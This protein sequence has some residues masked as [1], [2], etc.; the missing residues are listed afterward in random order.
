MDA[1]RW[2]QIKTLFEDAAALPAS[3]RAALLDTACADDPA[4]RAEVDSLLAAQDKDT[5]FLE[6]PVTSDALALLEQSAPLGPHMML[7]PYHLLREIGHGGMGVVYLAERADGQYERRVAIKL[8]RHGLFSPD[9]VRRFQRERQLL[10][11][12]N[13]PGIARLIGGGVSE[14]V[15]GAS[16]GL[17][18]LVMEY[19][20]GDPITAFASSESLT[21]RRRI[22]L[23]LDVCEAVQHANRAL[24]V[25]RDLKPSNILVTASGTVKL[26]DFGVARLIE[27]AE[28]GRTRTAFGALTPSYAAPEQIQG[29]PAT[30]A[31]DVYALGVLLYELLTGS[32]P[33]DVHG[34]TPR[35]IE[36]VICEAVPQR[37]SSAV[38]HP[39]GPIP[40]ALGASRDAL[41]RTLKG[42]LD[43]IVMTALEKDPARRY[44]SAEQLGDDLQRHLA[45]L[46]IRARPS[47]AA[48]RTARFIQRHTV[49]LGATALIAL[50]LVIG[51]ISTASQARRAER[52]TLEVREMAGALLFEIHDAIRD[53]PG[54]TPARQTLVSNA[55][56][57]LDNLHR[58]A[59]TDPELALDLAAAYD[60]IGQIQGDPHYTNLGDIDGALASYGKALD[61]RE[62]LWQRDSTDREVRRS[63]ASS[64]GN[65]AVVAWWKGG[66]QFSPEQ[67]RSRA[68]DLLTPM[69][70]APQLDSTAMHIRARIQSEQGWDLI[71]DGRYETGLAH[72]DTAIVD[73]EALARNRPDDL[74]LQLHLWRAY[75]YQADGLSFSS[76]FQPLLDLMEDKG[77]PLLHTLLQDHPNHPRILY[78]LH[79]AENE[80][81]SAQA[82]FGREQDAL[83]ASR[84]SLEYADA[85]LAADETNEKAREAAG[86]ARLALAMQLAGQ[87]Q[88]DEAE[89]A[90][91]SS[92]ALAQARFD[93]DTTN[94][95]AGNRLALAQRFLCRTL[96]GAERYS[97]ALE[98]CLV[99]IRN[100]EHT[101]A[102]G[103]S[104]ILQ[105]NL[106]SAYGHTARIYHALAR[107]ST[108]SARQDYLDAA[109]RHYERGIAILEE[110][111]AGKEIA[112][113]GDL[114][115][116]VNPDT[117]ASEYQIFLAE[118]R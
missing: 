41:A 53:L 72:L 38:V 15:P 12:L 29:E 73:L 44:A 93:E 85:M 65:M 13:H 97:E 90:H 96:A 27:E 6:A 116:E 60:E 110:V 14:P 56:V 107:Q 43:T 111:L 39:S 21:L 26:L 36:Q 37:P 9:L 34:M 4:L 74:S 79:I 33:Y 86:R 47:T 42:D 112:D 23:F 62:T 80:R 5:P 45:R 58:E 11:S 109:R 31:T 117:L 35:D 8:V 49:G 69:T 99:S 106:G 46:P 63:L 94:S 66:E 103:F 61:L 7:G 76:Q 102:L 88:I 28:E 1:E 77:L 48:Y 22:D 3:E 20:E 50:A 40:E 91:V 30:T 89:E 95:E 105:S 64:Y 17:P 114:N 75:S 55:L 16:G 54:A 113:T 104:S 57:Y 10:A 83:A 32:R 100:Q 68:M 118:L 67:L 82:A 71:F 92:I 2:Q 70:R 108:G 101:N 51:T 84:Q 81:S 18:Y 24:I 25:H 98:I 52:R 78:G 115:W 59:R 19:V 87:G